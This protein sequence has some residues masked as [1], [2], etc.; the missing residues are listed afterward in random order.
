MFR[1]T[2][3]IMMALTGLPL[4]MTTESMAAVEV[5]RTNPVDPYFY[6]DDTYITLSGTVATVLGNQFTLDYDTGSITVVMNDFYG[7]T[8]KDKLI[9]G[10][11]VTVSGKIDDDLFESRKIMAGGVYVHDRSV[12]YYASMED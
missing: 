12:H 5:R 10:E 4:V 7:G 6:A 2:L 1:W 11:K 3:L 9:P 8:A